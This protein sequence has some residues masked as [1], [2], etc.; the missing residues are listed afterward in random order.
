MS[1]QAKVAF[2]KQR[3]PERFCRVSRC[4]WR[5]VR[6]DHATQMFSARPDCPNGFCP[7]HQRSASA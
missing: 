5:V 3:H 1:I 7:R 4:L 2:D 6:L